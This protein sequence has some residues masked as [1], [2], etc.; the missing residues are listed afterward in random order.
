[1]QT[2]ALNS[3][4]RG[5][6]RELPPAP[7]AAVAY[8]LRIWSGFAL[9]LA[10]LVL[11]G[12][13]G[14]RSTHSLINRDAWVN[15]TRIVIDRLAALGSTVE[16]LQGDLLGYAA[17]DDGSFLHL[18]RVE[19]EALEGDIDRIR[20]LIA[21]NPSQSRRRQLD[22]LAVLVDARRELAQRT[23]AVAA[24]GD[25]PTAAAGIL[26]GPGLSL[27]HEIARRV[28]EMIAV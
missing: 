20:K 11:V 15:Y 9:A 10:S 5:P 7:V 28:A 18:A 19:N 1:M 3:A 14:L 17:T 12:T 27:N 4:D 2:A 8:G 25:F 21:D 23:I 6:D 26:H 22:D 13:V 16:S 24:G